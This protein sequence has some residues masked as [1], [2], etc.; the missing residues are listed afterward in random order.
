MENIDLEKLSKV[1]LI[2]IIATKN[3]IISENE[4]HI[5]YKDLLISKDEALIKALTKK[6]S[7]LERNIGQLNIERDTLLKELEKKGFQVYL[8]RKELF[9]SKS[10]Q[11]K[12][13]FKD[14]FVF[15][16]TEENTSLDVKNEITKKN[17]NKVGRKKDTQNYEGLINVK[18]EHKTV[19]T[20][21]TVCPNCNTEL[22][23]DKDETITKL[24][25]VPEKFIKIIITLKRKRCPKCDY[26]SSSD[27]IDVFGKSLL[28]NSLASYLATE[29]FVK[30]V[31]LYR[32][33]SVLEKQGIKLSRQ[34]QANYLITLASELY[35]IYE[36]MK[37]DLLNT[38]C[39]VIHA[40][41][42]TLKVIKTEDD[43]KTSYIWLYGTSEY[44]PNRILIYEYK[45]NRSGKN[46][47]EFLK[48]YSGYLVCDGYSGY[49]NIP[50]VF[51]A[52]CYFHIRK[53]Y[54]EI[55]NSHKEKD[56]ST[57]ISSK[58][59]TML[60]KAFCLERTYKEKKLDPLEICKRRNKEI[61]PI[62]DKFFAL[63]KEKYT[64]A[65][66][67]LKNAI[68]YSLKY[69]KDLYHFLEDGHIPMTNNLAERAIKSFVINRKNFL[70]AYTEKGA[71]ASAIIMSIIQTAKNN[72][73]K[74]DQYLEYVLS[75]LQTTKQSEIDSLLPYSRKL[76]SR[77][78]IKIKKE[79][80][81]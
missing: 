64:S 72:L 76:P 14:D 21:E 58:V 36:K 68:E 35:P 33:E 57:S 22:V 52:R 2:S 39:K 67:P 75:H 34:L 25:H 65:V 38:Q 40:D 32:L 55:I 13:I 31:P 23:D 81:K 60:E 46:P 3:R 63:I 74:V 18:T 79:K 29:K 10:E 42:T 7:K 53:K 43:R 30:G 26:T 78:R 8:Q 51:P 62:I 11:S 56:I 4:E 19:E 24:I 15:N 70:F 5:K 1:E 59:I 45:L 71:D 61:R 41:E 16:E 80:K 44:D 69:E 66:F 50:N 17:K 6:V 77:I 49:N 73:L 9:G 20:K 37:S 48:D 54:A 28:S 12:Y 27:D 47:R